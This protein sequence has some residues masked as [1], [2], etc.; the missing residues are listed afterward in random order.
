VLPVQKLC[1]HGQGMLRKV[2]T[3]DCVPQILL[4]SNQ[5]FI[6][7]ADHAFIVELLVPNVTHVVVPRQGLIARTVDMTFWTLLM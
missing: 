2:P 1:S 4:I 6:K 7:K 3:S 5:I